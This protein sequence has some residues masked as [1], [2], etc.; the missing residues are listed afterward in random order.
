MP[1]PYDVPP[2]LLIER[3]S[4]YLKNNVDEVKPPP[5][6][7]IVK[8]GVYAQ[9]PPQDPD[10]W[11]IRCASLLRKIYIKGPIGIER[12]RA[13]YGG[14]KD[15]GTLPEHSRK[16]SGAI[17][18]KVLQQL[19]AAGFVET[20]KGR[21]R[22]ITSKGRSLLDSLSTEIKRELEEENPELK[23]Y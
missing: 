5:W 1:T 6:V 14:R 8:T 19:E 15:R 4:K 18:R 20:L 3:L 11:F 9:R 2:Q 22:I 10:W 21:G 17:I 23:K 13:E 12:L 16:G 7:S